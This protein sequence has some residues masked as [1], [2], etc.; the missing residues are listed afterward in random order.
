MAL[1]SAEYA[2]AP[3][4]A[5]GRGII[6]ED[7]LDPETIYI[8]IFSALIPCMFSFPGIV[9]LRILALTSV[10]ANPPKNLNH[11]LLETNVSLE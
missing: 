2:A 10:M 7:K 6:I 3:G 4:S 9:I 8:Y 5:K 11:T 1:S